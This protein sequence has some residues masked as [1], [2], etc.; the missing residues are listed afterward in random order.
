MWLHRFIKEA[1]IEHNRASLTHI[2]LQDNGLT[3]GLQQIKQQLQENH[4]IKINIHV[5][6]ILRET[7][8]LKAKYGILC[9]TRL[10]YSADK[11]LLREFEKEY[12]MEHQ[13]SQTLKCA[14]DQEN[15]L[16]RKKY[17]Q[18]DHRLDQVYKQ[19]Q[20]IPDS[21]IK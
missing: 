20:L 9:K 16:L 5:P 2:E 8:M 18:D 14:L 6:E 19:W 1:R 10:E 17:D 21:R 7:K 13:E 3:K 15:Q 11:L 12:K 4:F